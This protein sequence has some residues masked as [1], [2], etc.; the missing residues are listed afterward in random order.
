MGS[1]VELHGSP[2]TKRQLSSCF[3]LKAKPL[4]SL[5][6][7]VL[8]AGCSAPNVHTVV[9]ASYD[10]E[11]SCEQIKSEIQ[12]NESR[13]VQ[14]AG[15]QGQSAASSLANV[16]EA[17]M[18]TGSAEGA[19]ATLVVGL[20]VVLALDVT[21]YLATL[22]IQG[23]EGDEVKLLNQRNE[24]LAALAK[25]FGC[26][27]AAGPIARPS[28]VESRKYGRAT[29]WTKIEPQRACILS[30]PKVVAATAAECTRQGGTLPRP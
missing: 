14:L 16:G 22:Q 20:P 30:G 26:N 3:K 18:E 7:C 27:L 28:F 8:V 9:V 23:W 17:A 11:M 19:A 6:L 10:E 2:P 1:V 13:A 15:S 12:E 21:A 24:R 5:V 25:N 4:H 29:D